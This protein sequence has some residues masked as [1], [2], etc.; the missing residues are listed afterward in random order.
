MVTAVP[1]FPVRRQDGCQAVVPVGRR[2]ADEIA[3][4]GPDR[5]WGALRQKIG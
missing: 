3:G 4:C 5:S 2:V 1:S